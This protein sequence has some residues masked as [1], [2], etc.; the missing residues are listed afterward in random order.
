[1]LQSKLLL[2]SIC[3]SGHKS[4]MVLAI[5][6]FGRVRSAQEAHLRPLKYNCRPLRHFEVYESHNREHDSA[7][8]RIGP[9]AATYQRIHW[10]RKCP[11]FRWLDDPISRRFG[12]HDPARSKRRLSI[13]VSRSPVARKSGFANINKWVSVST[14]SEPLLLRIRCA[15]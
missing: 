4:M 10:E 7:I 9:S 3:R 1:M 5:T 14:S 15:G 8:N 12:D 6:V 2:A 11:V 13:R